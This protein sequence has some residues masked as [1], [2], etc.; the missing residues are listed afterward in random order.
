MAIFASVFFFFFILLL[1]PGVL[2][3]QS[4]SSWASQI[5]SQPERKRGNKKKTSEIKSRP[6]ALCDWEG[7][8]FTVKSRRKREE[9]AVNRMGMGEC[10]W[11]GGDKRHN[12]VLGYGRWELFVGGRN[13]RKLQEHVGDCILQCR[14]AGKA[15]LVGI[16]LMVVTA[17][18]ECWDAFCLSFFLSVCRSVCLSSAL[19]WTIRASLPLFLS[20]CVDNIQQIF[21]R[22]H[23]SL[24]EV[25]FGIIGLTNLFKNENVYTFQKKKQFSNN[26]EISSRLITMNKQGRSFPPALNGTKYDES[27]IKEEQ[28]HFLYH[29]S[30]PRM[31]S[32]RFP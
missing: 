12:I 18:T 16:T 17:S 23:F 27:S 19:K 6:T 1:W 14:T 20:C 26:F 5:S 15:S 24:E 28:V 9:V 25:E 32:F 8:H 10:W 7:L 29:V 11:G 3:G 2:C 21:K 31:R 13:G 4:T 22:S 30:F